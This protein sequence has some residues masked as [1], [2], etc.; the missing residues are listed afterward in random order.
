MGIFLDVFG[1][2]NVEK[3]IVLGVKKI[4]EIVGNK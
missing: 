2:L 1:D 3:I 4:I